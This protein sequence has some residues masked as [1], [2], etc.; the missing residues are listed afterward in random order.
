M[1]GRLQVLFELKGLE[2]AVPSLRLTRVCRLG[3][4]VVLQ[5]GSERGKLRGL[6]GFAGF[7]F[8]L[9]KRLV[10]AGAQVRLVEGRDV[11]VGD[12]AL[13]LRVLL[14]E[15]PLLI[16]P[17]VVDEG[18]GFGVLQGVVAVF[19][20]EEV[21]G[22]G[23]GL[24]GRLLG[25]RLVL[26]GVLEHLV[27]ADGV[28]F[29]QPLLPLGLR[30]DVLLLLHLR[31]SLALHW[32][33]VGALPGVARLLALKQL[34]VRQQPLLLEERHQLLVL[35]V[36]QVLVQLPPVTVRLPC[37]DRVALPVLL[38]DSVEVNV[39]LQALHVLVVQQSV[40]AH[41]LPQGLLLRVLPLLH[42]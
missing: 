28:V 19:L 21:L 34:P 9:D 15:D 25:P 8:V 26:E 17:L 13:R 12:L 42:A 23:A 10:P 38:R 11:L 5:F 16:D 33:L 3:G 39:L 24:G 6:F 22:A 40:R 2:L 36:V 27:E 20:L 35:Q 7:D 31:G 4:C 14:L 18:A 30:E 37:E 41:Q 1:S 32:L 29:E